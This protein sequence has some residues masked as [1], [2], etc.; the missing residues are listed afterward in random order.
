MIELSVEIEG[1][2][3]GLSDL[4]NRVQAA[5][6]LEEGVPEL[7]SAGRIVSDEEIWRVN[8]EFRGI[9]RPTDV[10][11]FPSIQYRRGRTAKDS[12]RALSRERDPESRLPYIGDF[13]ISLP[14]AIRQAEEYGHSVERELCYLTAHAQF[15]LMGYD[16]MTDEDKRRM[17]RCED[18]VMDALG[19]RRENI[20]TDSELF[21]LA[22]EALKSA[23]APY[24]KFFVGAALETSDGRV[25]TGCNIE[26]AS[27]G[28]TICAERTAAVKAVSE[29]AT[30]FK[31][32]AVAG[33]TSYAWPCGVCRQFLNEFSDGLVVICGN[34]GTG[35]FRSVP[36]MELLPH[37]FGPSDLINNTEAYSD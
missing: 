6:L 25:F 18:S 35:E 27:Y 11:S 29:G 36:L 21:N 12:L 24:S 17:R 31:R 4:L 22:A 34:A 3:I 1:T 10:L 16:H 15:H 14:T 32:I 5:C 23:Y 7:M 13:L 30:K 9:D 20:L 2:P 8:R 26:N 33:V 19:I 37:S 28:A